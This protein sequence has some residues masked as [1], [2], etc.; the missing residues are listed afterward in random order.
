MHSVVRT[1]LEKNES[2]EEAMIH[3]RKAHQKLLTKESSIID[4]IRRAESENG[5]N[6]NQIP[7][8]AAF[9]NHPP[10][11]LNQGHKARISNERKI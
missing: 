3:Y 9:S 4:V 8:L 11:D 1:L 2:I 7:D 10:R 6:H 5:S